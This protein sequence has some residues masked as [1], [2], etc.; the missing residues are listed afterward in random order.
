MDEFTNFSA[1]AMSQIT[2][3]N[4]SQGMEDKTETCAQNI[5]GES[6]GEV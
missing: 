2:Q 6:V 4:L 1:K 5:Q 3:S